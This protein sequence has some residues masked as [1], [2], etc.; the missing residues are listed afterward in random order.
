MELHCSLATSLSGNLD[1]QLKV[2][3][4]F[5]KVF[6]MIQVSVLKYAG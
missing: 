3:K 5:H 1:I 2:S 4:L 6:F